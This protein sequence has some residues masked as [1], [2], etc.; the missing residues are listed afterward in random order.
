MARQ[1]AMGFAAGADLVT[2]PDTRSASAIR[3]VGEVPFLYRTSAVFLKPSIFR[4]H[5]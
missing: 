2:L 1:K 3:D 4:H 5:S